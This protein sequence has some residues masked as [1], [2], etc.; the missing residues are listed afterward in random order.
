MS[1]TNTVMTESESK[2]VLGAARRGVGRPLE[3]TEARSVLAAFEVSRRRTALLAL[4]L[5]NPGSVLE[6]VGARVRWR[7]GTGYK[8]LWT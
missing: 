3:D 5:E 4:L 7:P 2:L 1:Y 6:R 8:E